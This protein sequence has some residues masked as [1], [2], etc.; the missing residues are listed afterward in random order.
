MMNQHSKDSD[1]QKH[2]DKK[3]DKAPA[4]KRPVQHDPGVREKFEKDIKPRFPE[5]KDR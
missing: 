5:P 3:R 1:R 2:D 4:P